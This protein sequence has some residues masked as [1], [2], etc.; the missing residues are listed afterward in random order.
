MCMY[1]QLTPMQYKKSALVKN[2]LVY[3]TAV[4]SVIMQNILYNYYR[5]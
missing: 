4:Q 1:M 2:V 5:F 3:V